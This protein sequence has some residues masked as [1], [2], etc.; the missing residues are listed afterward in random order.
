MTT[1]VS[2]SRTTDPAIIA[3]LENILAQA[4]KGHIV[5][6]AIAVE[7]EDRAIGTQ[8]CVGEDGEHWRLLGALS[9]LMHRINGKIEGM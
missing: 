5:S 7:C 6:F 3:E 8:W 2:L 1:L 4:K 9:Q